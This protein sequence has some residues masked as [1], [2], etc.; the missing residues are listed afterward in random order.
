MKAVSSEIASF[1]WLYLSLLCMSCM[2]SDSMGLSLYP[3]LYIALAMV[4]NF[5]MSVVFGKCSACLHKVQVKNL[6]NEI[7]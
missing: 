3:S 6:A 2:A 5:A 7:N 1:V 4:F